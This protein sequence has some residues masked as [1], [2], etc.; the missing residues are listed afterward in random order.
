MRESSNAHL[1]I[2]PA[3]PAVTSSTEDRTGWPVKRFV[4]TAR[5]YRTAQI[6]AGQQINNTEIGVHYPDKSRARTTE[7]PSGHQPGHH[8]TMPRP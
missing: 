8:P 6:H 4:R 1:T 7:R 2:V 5:R 3:A